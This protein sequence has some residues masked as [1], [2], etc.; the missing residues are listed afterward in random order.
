[1]ASDSLVSIGYQP[2]GFENINQKMHLIDVQSEEWMTARIRMIDL[3][4]DRIEQKHGPRF[5]RS[6]LMPFGEEQDLPYINIRI[7]DLDTISEIRQM[8]QVR[9]VDVMTFFIE[10]QTE[11]DFRDGVGCTL[12][13]GNPNP[14]DYI[15]IT[16]QARQS[17]HIDP[18]NGSESSSVLH[19]PKKVSKLSFDFC[20]ANHGC[21]AANLFEYVFE[22]PKAKLKVCIL[23]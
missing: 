14:A 16:P 3:I 2:I 8:P 20:V 5:D 12:Y 18:D 10:D 23:P 6:Y 1:M 15:N 9:Y 19:K 13:D 21:H 7:F 17:W 4:L 22:D 11:T